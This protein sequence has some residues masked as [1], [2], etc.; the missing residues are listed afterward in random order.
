VELKDV[1]T[2]ISHLE[3]TAEAMEPAAYGQEE[4]SRLRDQI[5]Q[6]SQDFPKIRSIHEIEILTRDGRYSIRLHGTVDG[7]T[8]LDE[9]HEIVT[10]ME[11]KIK[12]IDEKVERVTIHCEPEEEKP[13]AGV[14]GKRQ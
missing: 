4:L 2:I 14:H 3:P 8:S 10:Q 12:A 9:A 11:E 7:S 6:I 5:V 1:S 13:L